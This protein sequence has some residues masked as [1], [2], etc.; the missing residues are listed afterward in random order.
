MGLELRFGMERVAKDDGFNWNSLLRGKLCSLFGASMQS[1]RRT[2]KMEN[3]TVA[4]ASWVESFAAC[5]CIF[6]TTKIAHT[7]MSSCCSCGWQVLCFISLH[8]DLLQFH[9]HHHLVVTPTSKLETIFVK[10]IRELKVNNFH[11]CAFTCCC[12]PTIISTRP[13][14]IPLKTLI[15]SWWVTPCSAWLFTDNIKS[16]ARE[17]QH[18]D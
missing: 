11:C 16:P 9:H 3:F 6:S 8:R 10:S 7:L 14:L 12:R 18:E 1:C 15:A 5:D 17:T 2:N 4:A 13:V